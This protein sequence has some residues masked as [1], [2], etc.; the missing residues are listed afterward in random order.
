MGWPICP[1]TRQR[2]ECCMSFRCRSVLILIA[3]PALHAG[4]RELR[5]CAD[6]NNLPFSNQAGEGIENR[7]AE[8]LAGDLHA[9]LKYT[10]FAERKSFVKN[11]LEADL[12]DVVMGVPSTLD[13]V[14]ATKPYYSST[15]AF[16]ERADRKLNVSSL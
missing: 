5:V 11:S 8:I 2:A 12:C 9:S 4:N 14:L 16:V 3:L 13:S 10:W 1:T 6:P 15:Y 7:L